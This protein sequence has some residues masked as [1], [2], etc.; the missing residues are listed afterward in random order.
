MASGNSWDTITYTSWNA[1]PPTLQW[2]TPQ[3]IGSETSPALFDPDLVIASWFDN[4]NTIEGW[5]DSD[6]ILSANSQVYVLS[7]F[8]TNTNTFYAASVAVGA[9]ALTP[10]RYDNINTFY[11]ATVA[12]AGITQNL[13]ATRYDNSSTFYAPTV[14]RGAVALTP[15]LYSNTNTFYAASISTGAVNLTPSLYSNTNTFYAATVGRG[16]VNLTPSLYSNTNAF[17]TQTVNVGVV[18]LA[19]GLYTNTNTFYAPTVGRGSVTLTV[20]L[21]TNSNTFYSP[22]VTPGAVALTASLY[23]NNQAFY[24]PTVSAASSPQNLAPSLY[25]NTNEFYRAVVSD[26]TLPASNETSGVSRSRART[27]FVQVDDKTYPVQEDQVIE[28]LKRFKQPEVKTEQVKSKAKVVKK[29]AKKQP[30]IV[31]KDA[32]Y[33]FVM[34]QK[35]DYSNA[36]I[37]IQFRQ[38]MERYQRDMEDEEILMLI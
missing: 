38:A 10:S 28:F 15:S 3:W 37:E 8:I 18:N 29:L 4:T 1:I 7:A 31:I 13:T 5:F 27:V 9:S 20:A 36:I 22:S 19:A 34:P 17:Y 35:T 6:L 32:P 25:S 23:S 12:S 2:D 33:D 21:F 30:E 14:G 11:A 24:A 26:G 16:A